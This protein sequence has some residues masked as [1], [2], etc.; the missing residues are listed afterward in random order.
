MEEN[1]VS[2]V[3]Y[4]F[5][6]YIWKILQ[7]EDSFLVSEDELIFSKLNGEAKSNFHI[8]IE[9]KCGWP[10]NRK[11]KVFYQEFPFRFFDSI[12]EEDIHKVLFEDEERHDLFIKDDG[13]IYIKPRIHLYFSNG[14]QVIRYYRTNEDAKIEFDKLKKKYPKLKTLSELFVQ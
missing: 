8:K 1:K 10:W 6:G 13:E 9:K 14:K 4:I 2:C 3:T 11:T 7:N 5:N 12:K